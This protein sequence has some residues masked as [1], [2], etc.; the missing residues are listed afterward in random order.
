[1][2]VED[3]RAARAEALARIAGA[4]RPL[5]EVF[6]DLRGAAGAPAR[7][8]PDQPA[9]D[10]TPDATPHAAPEPTPEEVAAAPTEEPM[11]EAAMLVMDAL[12]SGRTPR[13]RFGDPYC[14]APA[15]YG[16]DYRVI[17]ED[18]FEAEGAPPY[19]AD[20]NCRVIVE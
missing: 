13:Q 10:A 1:M 18:V 2:S 7:Q 12:T 3:R 11:S 6:A 8:Q 17:D 20:C 15:C 5:A 19:A 16:H 14:P 4:H 9:P